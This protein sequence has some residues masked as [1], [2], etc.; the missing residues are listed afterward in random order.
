MTDLLA[1]L[2]AELRKDIYFRLLGEPEPIQLVVSKREIA[3]LGHHRNPKHR[4]LVWDSR[5]RKWI[6]ATPSNTAILLADKQKYLEAS[7]VLC[8]CN[9]DV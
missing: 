4:G 6:P 2:P 8:P 3:R 1:L 7:Q 9:L 5:Q